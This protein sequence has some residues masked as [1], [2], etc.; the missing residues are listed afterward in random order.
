MERE[1][2]IIKNDVYLSIRDVPESILYRIP[3]IWAVF[4]PDPVPDI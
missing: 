2:N 4:L 3:D 1:D